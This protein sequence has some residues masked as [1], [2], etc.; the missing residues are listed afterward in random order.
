MRG[1]G[2]PY[3]TLARKRV[4]IYGPPTFAI[5]FDRLLLDKRFNSI[6]KIKTI[7]ATYMAASGLNP[8]CKTQLTTFSFI[9]DS[10]HGISCGPLVSGVIG[11]RKPVYD[12]WGNT[13][14][15]AARMETTGA[16]DRIQ[17]TKYTKQLLERI[18]YGLEARGAVEVKGKGRM[19]TWWVVSERGVAPTLEMQREAEDT[20]PA[21]NENHPRSLAAILEAAAS[22]GGRHARRQRRAA[23]TDTA[24]CYSECAREARSSK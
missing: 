4:P 17:V 9:R 15:E 8:N 3:A 20:L 18:G 16:M 2:K 14:N 1:Q 5:D 19:E 6:E 24:P 21:D 10:T 13:V 23:P 11:A 7:G 22:A 12:I